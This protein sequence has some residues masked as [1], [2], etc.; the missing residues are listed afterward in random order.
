MLITLP[1][2]IRSFLLI[3]T[4]PDNIRSLLLISH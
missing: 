2:N 1:D 4:L 3:I